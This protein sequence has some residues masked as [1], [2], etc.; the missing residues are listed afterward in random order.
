MR[1]DAKHE[2]ESFGWLERLLSRHKLTLLD[3]FEG[4]YV[5]DVAEEQ[6]DLRDYDADH[7]AEGVLYQTVKHSVQ[8]RKNGVQRRTKFMRQSHLTQLKSLVLLVLADQLVTELDCFYLLRDVIEVDSSCTFL[9]KLAT[10]DP[11]LVK[12]LQVRRLAL[13]HIDAVLLAWLVLL[14]HDDL[15][16]IHG[17]TGLKLQ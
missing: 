7:V 16:E 12:F 17:V 15:F 6:I 5:S 1:E 2:I 9:E 8:N 3:H 4:K 14:R 10:L 13:Q 11:D